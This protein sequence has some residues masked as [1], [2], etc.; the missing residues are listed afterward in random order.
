MGFGILLFGYFITTM[1][2]IPLSMLLPIDLTG[3]IRMIGYIVVIIAA[4]KLKDYSSSFDMLIASSAI[5]VAVSSI[6]GIFDLGLFLVKNQIVDLPFADFL[7][8][9]SELQIVDYLALIVIFFVAS[10]CM[11]IKR[12]GEDT[13]I[14]RIMTMATRNLVFY[15]IF[16]AVKAIS[17]LPFSWIDNNANVF[18]S[19]LLIIELVCWMLNLYMIFYCYAKVC[20]S[21]DVDMK[22]KP[23]RFD[24][25]NKRRAKREEERQKIID[26]FEEKQRNKK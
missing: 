23:S 26:E 19:V 11:S 7:K 2:S 18:V 8:T 6:E 17:F 14:K 13:G 24:F 25:V 12:I 20:D 3:F 4:K 1:V 22:Q 5:M 9:V 21:S 15:F 16:F 10:L